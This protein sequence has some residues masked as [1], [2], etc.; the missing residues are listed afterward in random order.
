M[1]PNLYLMKKEKIKNNKQFKV[2]IYNYK[3]SFLKGFSQKVLE[4]LNLLYEECLGM[5]ILLQYKGIFQ[6]FAIKLINIL[7][8]I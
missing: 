4:I 2:Y 8:S 7:F 5:H 6:Y 3:E 1:N